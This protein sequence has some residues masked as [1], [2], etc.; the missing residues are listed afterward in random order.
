MGMKTNVIDMTGARAGRVMVLAYAG[1]KN[2]QAYWSCAC[3]C[4]TRFVTQ[5]RFLRNGAT[6]SCGCL[7]KENRA[8]ASAKAKTTHGQTKGGARSRAHSIWTNMRS[9][10]GN[11]N[12]TS[13]KWYGG[14]GIAVCERWQSFE[15]FFA[16]MGPPPDGASIDRINPDGD[17]TP[18]NCRWASSVKQA[19]NTRANKVLE[20]DGVFMTV[21]EWSRQPGACSDKTIY[22]RIARGWDSKRAVFQPPRCTGES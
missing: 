4:G 3:D 21:A 11:Q 15:N 1:S 19:N 10:C 2:Q 14:R 5:G 6:R 22:A 9:R 16:D 12:F 7:G 13:Y 20:V 8:L 17:Y 18:E